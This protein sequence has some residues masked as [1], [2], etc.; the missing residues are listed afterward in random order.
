LVYPS[1]K[2]DSGQFVSLLHDNN[3]QLEEKYPPGT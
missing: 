1:I 2:Y 3:P